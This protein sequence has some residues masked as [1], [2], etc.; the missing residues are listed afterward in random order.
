[1]KTRDVW[2]QV[3]SVL[4]AGLTLLLKTYCCYA[5]AFSK[6]FFNGSHD[7]AAV[8]SSKVTKLTKKEALFCLCL[9]Y[10]ASHC[11]SF[12]IQTHHATQ[13][14]RLCEPT[15]Q[16]INWWPILRSTSHTANCAKLKQTPEESQPRHCLSHAFWW[17]FPSLSHH[18]TELPPSSQAAQNLGKKA[19]LR[20]K[21]LSGWA[22][23]RHWQSWSQAGLRL[24]SFSLSAQTLLS[25][26]SAQHE[27]IT[28]LQ[29]VHIQVCPTALLLMILEKSSQLFSLISAS[30]HII[31][32]ISSTEL[33][34]ITIDH[35][36]LIAVRGRPSTPVVT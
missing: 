17:G 10:L 4:G 32:P 2:C 24:I 20:I 34:S 11:S 16:L 9:T 28:S 21:P 8:C 29:N 35:L 13:A 12:N 31:S 36:D 27:K 15:Y 18:G 6:S 23:A 30:Q 5:Y 14:K 3:S 1:M 25:G 7:Y 26:D 19:T 33:F 22:T